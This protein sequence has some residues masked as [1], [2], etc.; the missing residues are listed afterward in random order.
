MKKVVS[1][2]PATDP[3]IS[4]PG[5]NYTLE[6]IRLGYQSVPALIKEGK[7]AIYIHPKMQ[8]R[9]DSCNHLAVFDNY[10]TAG[11]IY[12]D[13][14]RLLQLDVKTVPVQEALTALQALTIYMGTFT[15][16]CCGLERKAVEESRGILSDWTRNM[17][18]SVQHR[19]PGD[20][21]PWQQ[22]IFGESVRRTIL[23]SYALS[24]A[25]DSF[26]YGYCSNWLFLESL[27]FD[28]RPGLW[29]A[30]SP[31][32]WIAAAGVTT[33]AVVGERL[34]SFH[35]F[36]EYHA[37]SDWGFCGDAFLTLVVTS[38]NGIKK[39]GGQT[40]WELSQIRSGQDDKSSDKAAGQHRI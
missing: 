8:L 30:Q 37:H 21:S 34:S 7:P 32:A 33:G 10:D 38:H 36:A 4:I 1:C 22:W 17:L 29:M 40:S 19:K 23:M 15:L 24:M 11:V 39:P 3:A 16:S 5:Q 18:E 35:E 2:G 25:L 20:Q 14:G 27:P 6:L 12:E 9:G 13:F 28:R 26:S 31:Q